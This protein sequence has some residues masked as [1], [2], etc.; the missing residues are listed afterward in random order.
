MTRPLR[1]TPPTIARTHVHHT[2]LRYP[3]HSTGRRIWDPPSR[4]PPHTGYAIQAFGLGA[5]SEGGKSFI[6]KIKSWN[7]HSQ[8]PKFI[9]MGVS[10]WLKYRKNTL[11]TIT[12]CVR[13]CVPSSRVTVLPKAV[14]SVRSVSRAGRGIGRPFGSVGHYSLV[15][16]STAGVLHIRSPVVY[17]MV[18]LHRSPGQS[19]RPVRHDH[20]GRR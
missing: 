15:A 4:V 5:D 13:C 1:V 10:V 17:R 16:H 7:D 18:V 9:Y 8:A 6:W 3:A 11:P 2:R 19:T 12:A 20:R 14:G